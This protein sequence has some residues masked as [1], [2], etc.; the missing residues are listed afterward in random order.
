MS[1]AIRIARSIKPAVR[2]KLMA[3][4]TPPIPP[5]TMQPTTMQPDVHPL[6]S[7]M[8][9]EN[10]PSVVVSPVPGLRGRLSSEKPMLDPEIK[11]DDA[12]TK[13]SPSTPNLIGAPVPPPV[14]A[15]VHSEPRQ[16]ELSKHVGKVFNDKN[17]Q[18]FVEKHTGLKGVTATPIHGMF[19]GNREPSFII[20]HPDMTDEHT[21]FLAPA[22]GFGLQQD[23]AVRF[24]H[25][26]DITEGIPSMLIGTGNKLNKKQIDGIMNAAKEEGLDGAS[27]TLDGKA[28]KFMHFGGEENLPD[29]FDKID[30]VMERTKMPH[31]LLFHSDSE[32]IDNENYLERLHGKD[33]ARAGDPNS[34][35]EPSDIFKSVVGNVLAPYAKAIAGEGYRLSPERLAETHGLTPQE[36]FAVQDS[37]Y[38]SGRKVA[39]RTTIPLMTGEEQLDMRPTGHGGKPTVDDALFALQNR[40]A[41]KGQIELGDYSDK[42]RDM[43]ANDMAK[44]VSFHVKNSDKSAIGWYDEALRKAL[45]HYEEIFP[46]LKTDRDKQMLFHALLGVT[47]QGN[48]V[49][50]NSVYA[51]RLYNHIRNGDSVS[52][53]LA[54]LKGGFGNQTKAIEQN[55]E[56][57]HHL[58]ETNGYDKMRD[59]FNQKMSVSDWKKKLR[60][61]KTLFGPDGKSLAE[62]VKGGKDQK[63]TGWSVFGPK[64]GSFINNLHGDYSTLTADLWFSRTWN[65]LL[66]HNFVHTPIGENKQYQDFRDALKAEYEHHNGF[67]STQTP[68]KT[69]EGQYTDKKWLHGTD[70]KGMSPEDFKELYDDPDALLNYAY[71]LET[72]YRKGGYKNKSDLRRRAKNW[73]ENRENAVAAPRSGLERDFQQRTAEKAQEILR[74]KHNLNIDIADIQAALWFHEKEL[75]GKLGVA[76]EKAKPADYEDAAK[77]TLELFRNGD[78]YTVGTKKLKKLAPPPPKDP[79]EPDQYASGGSVRGAYNEGGTSYEPHKRAEQQGYSIKGYHVTRGSRAGQITSAKR[80]DPYMTGSPGEEASFFW[81]EPEA[82]NKWA[83]YLAGTDSFDPSQMTEKQMDRAERH[84]TAVMPV[85]IHPGKH[86]EVNWP[87]ET[88]KTHYDNRSMAKILGNAREQG[89]DT[90]RIKNMIEE[91]PMSIE[92][93]EKGKATG[94]Y[95]PAHDQIA[96]LNPHV[97]RSE[98]AE[99]DPRRQGQTDLGANRGGAFGFGGDVEPEISN[100]ISIFPKPQRM[101]GPDD[102]VAGG[103]YLSMPDKQDMTGHKS[104]AASI[105]IREG[106]KPYFTASKD[107]VDETGTSGRGNAIAKTNLFKQ[108]AGWQWKDAPEGH[109]DTSTIVSVEH[110][111]KHFYALNAHFPK[112][113]DFARY[114]NSPSEPRL[115]P[116]TRGNV[117]LGPQAGS[118]MVRGREHPVYHHVI[119]KA[120][121]GE[122]SGY[123]EGGKTL[124]EKYPTQY[125]PEVGRQVM[126]DGGEPLERMREHASHF[127][128][129]EI[130]SPFVGTKMGIPSQSHEH[131]LHQMDM[132]QRGPAQREEMRDSAPQDRSP[133]QE[134]QNAYLAALQSAA[135]AARRH[136][137]S[138]FEDVAKMLSK[139]NI[140]KYA[141]SLPS[142][143]E[144][145][146]FLKEKAGNAVKA[147]GDFIA[148]PA[149]AH[150]GHVRNGYALGGNPADREGGGYGTGN[151]GGGSSP[152]Y[153]ANGGQDSPSESARSSSGYGNDGGSGF[154]GGDGGRDSN[155]FGG[156]GGRDRGSF[157]YGPTEGDVPGMSQ[158]AFDFNRRQSAMEAEN[159]SLF[160]SGV[161]NAMDRA[162]NMFLSNA[163]KMTGPEAQSDL[164]RLDSA[165]NYPLVGGMIAN[166]YGVQQA[167][168][169]Q[170]AQLAGIV[171]QMRTPQSVPANFATPEG[172]LSRYGYPTETT[173]DR[174][175]SMGSVSPESFANASGN[176]PMPAARPSEFS[177][178]ASS[179]GR[180]D[181]SPQPAAPQNSGGQDTSIRSNFNQ[182]F[183]AAADS[184]LKVFPWKN[185]VTGQTQMY[186]VA[187]QSG[188]RALYPSNIV[189]HAL[190]KISAPPAALDPIMMAKRGRP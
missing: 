144:N 183:K 35:S 89:Y 128:G 56:K 4:G 142:A 42:A 108:K 98:Y 130:M 2:V 168:P 67:P 46:E 53:A 39:D 153:S 54:K 44:E 189:E 147:V 127:G 119:V 170:E 162:T 120:D 115:R 22:L 103:Q 14:Q 131:F 88:G 141:D 16:E 7:T 166:A 96:V 66:G 10:I 50:E 93:Y 21:N 151:I 76:S 110:R 187:Y 86:L 5:T 9:K 150:G 3:G 32:L 71:N 155:P 57:F 18:N 176:I 140:Q 87:D 78:L 72:A 158:G 138:F 45:G 12:L 164:T 11:P 83:N 117:E 36:K 31:K 160:G 107:A 97:I 80:F 172:M 154:T 94:E 61:D 74:K 177:T 73:I 58:L 126:A 163:N 47:S 29:F 13:W 19:E 124:F 33:G 40:A 137:A 181:Y 173:P 63:V 34:P 23:S 148:P 25:N 159:N 146:G 125:L 91:G 6:Q 114:E 118:I 15:P 165:I 112:G 90:V 99:F 79:D 100:P 37:L 62:M 8:Q 70:T 55:I 184:G 48:N 104:A 24:K 149:Y 1:D 190:N 51:A 169:A 175:G 139:E 122:V 20:S 185:P 133:Q 30:R 186:R 132:P 106:G 157:T 68:Y 43:I 134:E 92:D 95:P 145:I 105:G 28:V 69:S 129:E 26:P 75:F 60:S 85:R 77:H 174:A 49:Y 135:E 188:G 38:P 116:T 27:S 65:R 123:A 81:D 171:N 17:F 179:T 113:V 161:N 167:T 143:E 59:I 41:N 102:F 82:A 152:S 121:G 180:Q 111:G 109:E 182:A 52:D 64:I 101:F 178:M 136:G 156:N 84:Q